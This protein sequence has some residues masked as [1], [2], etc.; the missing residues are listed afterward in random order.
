MKEKY[1]YLFLQP[2]TFSLPL[3]FSMQKKTCPCCGYSNNFVEIVSSC[4]NSS[5]ID[6]EG[7]ANDEAVE[8]PADDTKWV[9][10]SHN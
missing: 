3:L 9:L 7:E 8:D 4:K 5:A 2:S 6:A 10:G 1:T